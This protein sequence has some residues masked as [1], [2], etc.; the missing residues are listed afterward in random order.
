MEICPALQ[1]DMKILCLVVYQLANIELMNKHFA[2]F[3]ML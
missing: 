2:I 3:A 1:I